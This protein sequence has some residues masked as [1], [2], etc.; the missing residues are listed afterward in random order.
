MNL[1]NQITSISQGITT[2]GQQVANDIGTTVSTLTSNISKVAALNVQIAA[3]TGAHQPTGDLEDQRDQAINAISAITDVTVISRP[4]GQVALYT[5]GGLLLL[6][7]GTAQTFSYNGTDIISQAGQI[8]TSALS[9]GSL[10]AEVNFLSGSAS[11]S[12]PGTGVI[13]K[14]NSQ[15][16]ALAVSLTDA[17][18]GSPQTFANAYNSATAGS[19]ELAS[20]F[21]TTDRRR[22]SRFARGQRQPSERQPTRSSRPAARRLSMP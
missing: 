9:G 4:S 14:L 18:A 21:F 1:A 12:D 11:S 19:G 2:L 20:G 13:G 15:I 6:D 17:T 16:Q 5:P 10:Q 7:G 22:R 3:A 8:V